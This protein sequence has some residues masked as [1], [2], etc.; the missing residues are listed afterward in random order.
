MKWSCILYLH[1]FCL[2]FVFS[3]LF[4][5]CFTISERLHCITALISDLCFLTLRNWNN[6]HINF[7][8]LI[9]QLCLCPFMEKC[10]L[11]TVS[12]WQSWT[13]F[14]GALNLCTV[15]GKCWRKYEAKWELVHRSHKRF[16]LGPRDSE[17][18][19]PRWHHQRSASSQV[20]YR[21]I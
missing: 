12:N 5:F 2:P 4:L 13:V 6:L 14:M 3:L 20:N 8:L 18:D 9:N 7:S 17:S 1:I 19:Y 10:S 15:V 16:K 21:V 11:R